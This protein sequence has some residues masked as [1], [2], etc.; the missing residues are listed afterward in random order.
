MKSNNPQE[1]LAR[2][3]ALVRELEQQNSR[4]SAEAAERARQAAELEAEKVRLLAVQDG[5]ETRLREALSE[6]AEL[7]R[8]LFGEKSEKL[9]TEEE[10][11]LA[12]LSADLQEQAQ[13]EPPISQ[14]VLEDE[15]QADAPKKRSRGRRHPL[16]EHLE[17][18]TVVIEPEVL[19]A[20]PECGQPP[21]CIGEETTEELDFIPAKLIVRRTVRR[22]YACRCGCGGVKV[23]PLPPRLLPQSKLGTALAVHLLLARFD[24]HVAYYTLERIFLERHHVVIRIRPVKQ[25]IDRSASPRGSAWVSENGS[26]RRWPCAPSPTPRA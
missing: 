17:R 12:E 10:A 22:K 6:L 20:C 15:A 11:Q 13:R 14:E 3:T 4:L 26:A 9:T 25:G 16:P 24:D 8:Q 21:G 19:D 1:E 7:K 18:Q 5:L 23:A 2:L